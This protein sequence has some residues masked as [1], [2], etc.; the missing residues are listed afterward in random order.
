MKFS[1]G[2]TDN[3]TLIVYFLC[4][5][6]VKNILTPRLVMLVGKIR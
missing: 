6:K 3:L 4:F 5:K 2:I 1:N